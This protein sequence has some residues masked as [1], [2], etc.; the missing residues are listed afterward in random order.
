MECRHKNAQVVTLL[1]NN[2]LLK[3]SIA[4]F[5]FTQNCKAA[6]HVR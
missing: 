5:T 3:H 4:K 6:R 2:Y 1:I